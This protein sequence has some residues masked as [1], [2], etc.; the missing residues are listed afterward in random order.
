[1]KQKYENCEE[2]TKEGQNWENLI[3]GK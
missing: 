2:N 3:P 1:M